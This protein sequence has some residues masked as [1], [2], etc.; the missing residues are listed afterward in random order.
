VTKNALLDLFWRHPFVT[1]GGAQVRHQRP[2]RSARRRSEATALHR[3]GVAARY[4]FIAAAVS[5]P[6]SKDAKTA[7]RKETDGPDRPR[8]AALTALCRGDAALASLRIASTRR[9]F[10]TELRRFADHSI[11]PAH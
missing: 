3:N 5:L 8:L 4:W 9:L 10:P 2:A 11:L 1:P 6:V 7:E